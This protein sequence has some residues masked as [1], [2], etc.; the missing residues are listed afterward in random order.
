VRTNNATPT[1]SQDILT[2]PHC[3]LTSPASSTHRGR[4]LRRHNAERCVTKVWDGWQAAKAKK[5]SHVVAPA[6]AEVAA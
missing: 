2:C 4:F 1:V 3:D 6:L 5:P